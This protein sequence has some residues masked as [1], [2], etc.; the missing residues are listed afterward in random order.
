MTLI[1]AGQVVAVL[2]LDTSPFKNSMK[3][4]GEDLKKFGNGNLDGQ[5]RVEALG[6]SISTVGMSMS[7]NFTVPLA[8][9]GAVATKI[10]VDFEA[11][12]S[13]VKAISGA[14][15]DDFKKLNDEAKRLGAT[16]SF[17]ASQ[18]AEGMENL[19]SA[20]FSVNEIMAAMPGM[21]DLAASD[22]IDLASAAEIAG[23][24]LR[25][26]GLEA[27]Q[28]AHVADVLARAAADT[29][30]G[31]TDTGEAMKYV[32]PV[33]SS[34]GL[35][36]EEV[37]AAIGEMSN[38][39]IKGGQAGTALRASL[40]R[41]ANP[42]KES[43]ELMESLG[44][45]AYDSSGKMLSLKDIVGNL[46]KSMNGLTEQEKQQ[47]I[48]TIF[49]QEAMSGMLAII[50]AGPEQLNSLTQSFKNSD[51]S[52]KE[53][54]DTM[55]DNLKGAW[56]NLTSAAEGAAIAVG[57]RLGPM[58]QD[59][60]KKINSV[61]DWFNNLSD[62]QKDN[63]VK[64]GLMVAAAGPLLL[65]GGKFIG[66]IGSI[67]GG[68]SKLTGAIKLATTATE[69]AKVATTV[70]NTALSATGAASV[71]G[72]AG[73]G[74]LA[75]SFGG[76][77]VAAGPWL[78]AGAAVVGTGYA[79][80]KGLTQETIPS[81][82]L[83]AD[84]VE[85]T[86]AT[87]SNANGYMYANM[88]TT[89]TK[90]SEST[91]K[92][93]GSY[94]ELDDGVRKEMQELYL[95]STIISDQIKNDMSSK[96]REMSNQVIQGY[97]KQKNDSITS[98]QEMFAESTTITD[99]EQANLLQ[100]TNGYYA[101]RETST[102]NHENSIN[103]ILTN[104]SNEKRALTQSET[105]QITALQNAMRENAVN[106]LS[107]NEIEAQVILQRMKD[108]DGRLTAEMT[109]EHISKL[110]G[111]RDNAVNAANSEYEQR[112]ATI[113]R[114]RDEAGAIS[115]E[116]ANKLIEEAK[117]QRDG[118]VTEAENTRIDAIN[119]MREMNSDLDNQ[120]D[121]NTGEILTT[122]DKLKRWWSGWKPESKSFSYSISNP[123]SSRRISGASEYATGS[124]SATRGI[125]LVGERG[126]ELVK[127]SGGERIYTAAESSRI[128]MNMNS[129]DININLDLAKLIEK[130][131]IIGN[132][133]DELL[134][135][136]VEADLN[137]SLTMD[138]Y[139]VGNAVA[140]IVGSKLA[141][142]TLRKR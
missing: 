48:A 57:E 116:Q 21:L 1:S 89:V 97:E 9:A 104:A 74:G 13:R 17:S 133:F 22:N 101:D 94:V 137:F 27:S 77:V 79:I 6:T 141:I 42:S 80:Y 113:T 10:F 142:S 100:K 34:M 51:G 73:V 37:T 96:F 71:A 65:I 135:T 136:E 67:V 39:G 59:V 58:L 103:A 31:I 7:K 16:T 129:S 20:G 121:T 5:K 55:R 86:A 11:Q 41:L 25:G 81:I 15:G 47:A 110:N 32:A 132:K 44:F 130:F 68:V 23:S 127:L 134:S 140:P 66:A 105:D 95:N 117:R 84:K 62:A 92:A 90:I 99:T 82:D 78:L 114:L 35:S 139:N 30:A 75:S 50:Q 29:N 53:M 3:S 88:E 69:T 63:V 52:A 38:A 83:F 14:T 119:K 49:G 85:T 40:T 43:A 12:M 18:A 109:A 19:A 64:I 60:A 24:T 28:A 4:A 131:N 126:P 76:L 72:T 70:A 61:V 26:F 128:A 91:K 123:P 124:Y 46:Q 108:Y 8:G 111:S 36:L 122:W 102:R 112:I 125:H 115:A 93:V 106:A 54:A 56:D 138:K 2:S 45:K 87:V 98:L 120:V 118:V 33:A 107:Q